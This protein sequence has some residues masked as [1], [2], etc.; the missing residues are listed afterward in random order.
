MDFE[1][2]DTVKHTVY[3]LFCNTG[4]IY[5]GINLPISYRTLFYGNTKNDKKSPQS[6]RIIKNDRTL[7]E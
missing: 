2:F 3:E 7:S 1:V 4:K 5:C 6:S